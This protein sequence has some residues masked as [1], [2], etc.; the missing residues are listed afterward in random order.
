[1][2]PTEVRVST[3][4]KLKRIAWLSGR[5]KSKVF[6]NLMHLFNEE[7]LRHCFHLLERNKAVGIDGVDKTE[8]E[9]NLDVNL[10]S[11]VGK[12]KRMSYRPGPVRKVLIPKE[13]KPG[14]TRP[15]GISNLEDKI[16]QKMFQRVL[17]CIYEPVFLDCSFGFRSGRGCHDAVR[18][19]HQHLYKNSVQVVID[20]DLANF[21]GTID[22]KLLEN[23]LR[24]KVQDK[25]FVRYI[26]RMFKSGVLSNGELSISDEGVPQGSMCSPVLANI[27]AHHVIDE[28]FE[29]VVKIHCS[30]KVALFRYCDDAVICCQTAYDA[31]R[32]RQALS[33]RLSKYRLSLNEEKTKLVEFAKPG[34]KG[35]VFDFLGFT[36]Y[37]GKSRNGRP[38]PK[39]K[40]SGKRISA[41]L[42]RVKDWISRV[43]NLFK[44]KDLWK[45]FRVK[46]RGHTQYYGVTFNYHCVRKFHNAAVR[47]MYKWLNRRSQRKSFNW[48]KFKR[49]RQLYPTPRIRICHSLI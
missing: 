28:W 34:G 22:H 31:D 16:I 10:K 42:K 27:F 26:I 18:A 17:E 6:N 11:L 21:F 12:L 35:K 15:L 8:Y 7:S 25:R 38:I 23:I 1:M 40:T 49:F 20:I 46:L 2:N 43:R 14:A 44:L 41:K 37:W 24:M 29:E 33:G 9:R 39:V 5:D 48:E 45:S 13:G 30:G 3:E 47:I 32:I 19:L 36:F 4:T